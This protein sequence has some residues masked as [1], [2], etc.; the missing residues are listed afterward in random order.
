MQHSRSKALNITMTLSW[1]NYAV[2]FV[3]SQLYNWDDINTTTNTSSKWATGDYLQHVERQHLAFI[4]SHRHFR[5][6]KYSHRY[7]QYSR[8]CSSSNNKTAAMPTLQINGITCVELASRQST[9]E[10]CVV[11]A[12]SVVATS[13]FIIRAGVNHI[14]SRLQRTRYAVRPVFVVVVST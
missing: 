14:V 6:F 7:T 8:N 11:L 1:G 9:V 4:K 2:T 10:S 13:L 12:G 3:N 5:P